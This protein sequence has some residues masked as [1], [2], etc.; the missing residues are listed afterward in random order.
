MRDHGELLESAEVH[1]NFYGTPREPVEKALA[2]GK[3]VLFDID[4]QGTEQLS[5]NTE[6]A[7]DLVR[8]FVLPPNFR[9]LRSRLE[10]RAEDTSETITKRLVNA[11]AE[12]GKWTQY[13][14]VIVNEDLGESFPAVRAILRAERQKRERVVGLQ[15]FVDGLLREAQEAVGETA[16]APS[17]SP[18]VVAEAV[19]ATVDDVAGQGAEP[20][21]EAAS[22]TAADIAEEES[23]VETAAAE[24]AAE[25]IV[26]GDAHPEIAD[27]AA[28]DVAAQEVAEEPAETAEEGPGD[29]EAEAHAAEP[30]N[31]NEEEAGSD[32]AGVEP[33]KT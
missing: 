3:D 20:D 6:H 7:A 29:T 13:D 19:A 24:V 9:E 31:E 14:Y 16:S 25:A 23:A 33:D 26:E 21:A 27:P 18:A 2:G 30:A 10:R 15:G 11:Q 17:D 4:W 22:D 8:V 28:E 1:G 32:S 5:Q 12:I